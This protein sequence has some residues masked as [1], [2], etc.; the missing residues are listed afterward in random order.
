MTIKLLENKLAYAESE[1]FK[2][3]NNFNVKKNELLS[4][5][6][7]LKQ[8]LKEFKSLELSQSKTI[9]EMSKLAKLKEKETY[10]LERRVENCLESNKRLK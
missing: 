2:L 1:A 3:S 7:D 9:A 4:E 6:T 8:S 10:N 5:I